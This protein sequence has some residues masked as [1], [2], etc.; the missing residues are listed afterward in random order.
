M[1]FLFGFLLK[2]LGGGILNK[3]MDYLKV[4][5]DSATQRERLKAEVVIQAIQAEV[6]SRQAQA[7]V[8]KV[9]HGW[10]V[11]ALIR[12]LF[13]YP[14]V[15]HFA[16]VV[17]DSIFLF[18]WDVAALPEPMATWEGWIVAAYFISRPAENIARSYLNKK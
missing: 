12:P 14:V 6:A 17:A 2:F 18:K 9:E 4:R 15:I 5:Q 16:L 8:L 1:T 11:T 13:A 10:W 3:V 7:E